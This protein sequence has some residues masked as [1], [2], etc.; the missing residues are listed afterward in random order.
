MSSFSDN[1]STA[2]KPPRLL[3]QV[4]NF[5]AHDKFRTEYTCMTANLEVK[6]DAQPLV[7]SDAW[8]DLCEAL[9]VALLWVVKWAWYTFFQIPG[10]FVGYAIVAVLHVVALCSMGFILLIFY[11]VYSLRYFSLAVWPDVPSSFS[12]IQQLFDHLLP[13][14]LLK[15]AVLHFFPTHCAL[16]LPWIPVLY[17]YI[18]ATS[19]LNISLP[20]LLLGLLASLD[21]LISNPSCLK[22]AMAGI[23]IRVETEETH[24]LTEKLARVEEEIRQMREKKARRKGGAKDQ[25]LPPVNQD[26]V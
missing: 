3:Q 24:A 18:G 2:P 17:A 22:R 19:L 10:A 25:P 4:Y 7:Y 5:F 9:L 6:P 1:T 20:H 12:P 21:N 15:V 23:V 8:S 14:H 16:S 26:A 13:F 11:Q